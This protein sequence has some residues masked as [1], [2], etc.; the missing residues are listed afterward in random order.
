MDNDLLD[1]LACE[2]GEIY[3]WE[4][5]CPGVYYLVILLDAA[6]AEEYYIVLEDAPISQEARA[7][8][9]PLQSAPVLTYLLDS[10]VRGAEIF[11]APRPAPA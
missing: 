5:E 10:E 11:D 4:E 9:R 6:N 7:M 2:L 8:G 3:R 1:L